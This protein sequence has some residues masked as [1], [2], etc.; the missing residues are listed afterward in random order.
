MRLKNHECI[1]FE[2]VFK[3]YGIH[4]SSGGSDEDMKSIKSSTR[5]AC[6]FSFFSSFPFPR[7]HIFDLAYPNEFFPA[8]P[9]DLVHALLSRTS[10]KTPTTTRAHPFNLVFIRFSSDR[11]MLFS[12]EISSSDDDGKSVKST[13]SAKR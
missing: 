5:Y 6:I 2:S 10:R 8:L 11:P 13:K 3:T 4:C 9:V 1:F 12:I 7:I